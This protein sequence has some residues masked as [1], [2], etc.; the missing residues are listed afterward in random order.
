M[1][2]PDK[3]VEHMQQFS[4][5]LSWNKD[6][7]WIMVIMSP[8]ANKKKTS[9]LLLSLIY[10]FVDRKALLIRDLKYWHFYVV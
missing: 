10:I 8:V 3:T 5:H 4:I 1:Q 9:K 2:T 7:I 6:K